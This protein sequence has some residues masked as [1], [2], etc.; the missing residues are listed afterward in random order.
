MTDLTNFRQQK[1]HFFA[2][3]TDSPIPAEERDSFEGLKY[4]PEAPELRFELRIQ[5]Y[6]DKPKVPIQT[7][8]GD[9]R[10]YER[11]GKVE[12]TVGGETASLTVYR[13]PHGFF[14]PFAD[15]LAGTETYGAGRYLDPEVLP[16]GRLVVDFNLAYNPYCVYNEAYSCPLTPAE[17][18]I[19]VPIRA[20]E[21]DY[22]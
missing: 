16:D 3:S 19:D 6:D 9:V 8:T 17:N 4:F 20:G 22:K 11:F 2:T 21:K 14:I 1:D 18:R 5:E 12:F 13:T 15:S 7:T 10:Q